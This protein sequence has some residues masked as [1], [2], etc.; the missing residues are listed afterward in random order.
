LIN[1]FNKN[2]VNEILL[3]FIFS[4]GS[5]DNKAKKRI[6]ELIFK[7]LKGKRP[8]DARSFYPI[9]HISIMMINI[10]TVF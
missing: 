5:K 9:P 6:L 1:G 7:Y 10:L 2:I 8:F 4:R 3:I